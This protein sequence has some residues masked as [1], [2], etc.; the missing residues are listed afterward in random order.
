MES[1]TT[2]INMFRNAKNQFRE[3][4]KIVG[5]S[6]SDI[7]Y[8]TTP[9]RVIIVALP[10]KMDDGSIRVLEGYRVQ[11]NDLR[12]PFKG[13]IR[14]H[15]DAD[16][17]DVKALAF[18][19]TWKCT[20]VD[21][22]FGGS[23]GGVVCDRKRMTDC[24][25]E[26]VSRAY[27]QQLAPFIGPGRDIPAPDMYTNPQV[28]GWMM[29]EFSKL[30]GQNVYGVVTGKPLHVGGSE[31]RNI[32]TGLGGAFVLD[33]AFKKFGISKPRIAVHGFGNA[34]ATAAK[35]LFDKGLKVIAVSDSSGGIFNE[36]GLDINAVKIQKAKTRKVTDF[37]DCKVISNEDLL[38][39]DAEVLVLSALHNTI[40]E[41]NVSDVRAKVILELANHPVAP[42]AEKILY[43]KK[44]RVIPDILAN[45]GGVVVSYFEWVQ[46]NTGYYWFSGEIEDKLRQK[47][48]A[49]FDRVYQT[50]QQHG[51]NLRTGAYVYAISVMQKVLEERGW[52]RDK[53]CHIM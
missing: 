50:A 8:L 18:L 12:G 23:K 17:D 49:A 5:L 44:I 39:L 43:D 25:L 9:K 19:M 3:A 52:S 15:P 21:I 41:H 47:M 10:I 31:V 46:N 11:F 30:K 32:A 6:E 24:E 40:T 48:A 4:A 27:I 13:G 29:D 28:M 34:G 51:T 7:L 42:E 35:V 14:F 37:T 22:P 26:R 38:R 2:K 45:A 16:I 53:M 33:E 20:V 36:N 1:G